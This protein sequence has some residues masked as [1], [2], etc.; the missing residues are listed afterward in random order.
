MIN[1]M[2]HEEQ[3]HEYALDHLHDEQE[4][5]ESVQE[6][7]DGKQEHDEQEHNIVGVPGSGEPI[8]D[9]MEQDMLNLL[10]TDASL[11]NL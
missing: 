11:L 7:Y 3:E 4:Y 1:E 9:E 6:D 8:I 2:V 10:G 5:D